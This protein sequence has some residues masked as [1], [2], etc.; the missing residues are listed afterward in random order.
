MTTQWRVLLGQ[1]TVVLH[2]IGSGRPPAGLLAPL[3]GL[4]ELRAALRM[5]ISVAGVRTL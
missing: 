1:E 3:A 2:L 5:V 4:G